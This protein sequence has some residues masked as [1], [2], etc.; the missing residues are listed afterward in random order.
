MQFQ[1]RVSIGLVPQTNSLTGQ[2][3][4]RSSESEDFCNLYLFSSSITVHCSRS[5]TFQKVDNSDLFHAGDVTDLWLGVDG[6]SGDNTPSDRDLRVVLR[7]GRHTAHL[8]LP[9]TQLQPPVTLSWGEVLN[10]QYYF[11]CITGEALVLFPRTETFITTFANFY[12]FYCLTTKVFL[13]S[14]KKAINS[15]GRSRLLA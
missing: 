4:L 8:L 5:K 13:I 6:D 11:N 7:R 2:V 9:D 12:D 1:R 14:L 10:I 15:K 3:I